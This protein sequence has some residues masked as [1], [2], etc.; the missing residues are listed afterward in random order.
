MDDDEAEPIGYGNG[1]GHGRVCGAGLDAYPGG[2]PSGG[3]GFLT[4]G[5]EGAIFA[6]FAI[7][8]G[9]ISDSLFRFF[10]SS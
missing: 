9:T 7:P 1:Y 8:A 3:E 10:S 2:G 4:G 6:N 5:T